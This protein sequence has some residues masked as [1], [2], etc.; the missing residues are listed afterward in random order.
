MSE[1][2]TLANFRT[3]IQTRG[4]YENS[5]DVTTTVLDDAINE[6]IKE[7]Y[8][9]LVGKWADYYTVL[10]N[11][12]VF[13]GDITG[14]GDS[15]AIASG[16]MTLTDAGAAFRADIVNSRITITGCANA[17]NNGTFRIIS[18]PTA[19][20]LTFENQRGV[21]E[22]VAL[23]WS[24]DGS[25]GIAVPA[26]FYKL[27][28]VEILGL[29]GTNYVKLYPHDLD[30]A[31]RYTSPVTGKGYRYRLQ[32]GNIMLVPDPGSTAETIRCYYIPRCPTLSA[33]SDSFDAINGYG[34]LVVQ[35]A[36]RMIKGDREDLDTSNIERQIDRM[37]QRVRVSADG[38]DAEPFYL[39]PRGPSNDFEDD[40]DWI[41]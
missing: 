35:L 14:T 34:E 5:A 23:A 33:A 38:R 20:T 2:V 15:L 32:A 41:R 16:I 24:I 28:K 10:S 17:A 11:N 9:I 4:G 12:M 1:L 21:A 36:L 40:E 30:A 3:A 25:A 13:V 22:T 29:D 31:H 6:A 39:D 37:S 7:L 27:R 26:D 8:D 18:R 19:T